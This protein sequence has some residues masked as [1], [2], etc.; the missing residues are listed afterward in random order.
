MVKYGINNV[1][2]GKFWYPILNKITYAALDKAMEEEI[3]Q[4]KKMSTII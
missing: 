3:K 4:T 2:G 1:R